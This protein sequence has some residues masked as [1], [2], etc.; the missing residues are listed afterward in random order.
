MKS[1]ASET[2]KQVHTPKLLLKSL[3]SCGILSS[4]W[5]VIVNII[6]AGLYPGYSVA[7][8]TVSELS[9]IDAPTRTLWVMLVIFYTLLLMVFGWGI[10]L[11]A[12][13]N[14]KL[15]F[16][17]GILIVDAVFGIF[18]PPMHQ[19]EVIAAGGGTLTDTLHLVWTYI[20]LVLILLMIGFGAAA[21]KKNFRI[22]SIATVVAFIVFGILTTRESPGIETGEP[23]PYIGIWERIN[24]GAYMLLIA[25]FA[26]VLLQRE[27]MRNTL[28]RK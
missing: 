14:K 26:V 15:R 27:K 7:S 19:R 11:S 12:G 28:N 24:V 2:G 8:Q 16:V 6:T 17:A 21:M 23:T 9:A 5:Y 1:M 20:H 22:Y 10:W 13:H 18:W 4:L 3:L 25:V